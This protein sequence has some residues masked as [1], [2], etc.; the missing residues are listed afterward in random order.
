MTLLTSNISNC[1]KKL[2]LQAR[3]DAKNC[4]EKGKE[5]T[6]YESRDRQ[7]VQ[8]TMKNIELDSIVLGNKKA[9]V[10]NGNFP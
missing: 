2:Y 1:G 3:E 10:K 5:I 8:L 7:N 4:M 9:R 6:L